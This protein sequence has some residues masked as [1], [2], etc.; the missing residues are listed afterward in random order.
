[1]I[2]NNTTKKYEFTGETKEYGGV[3]L[4]RIRRLSDKLLGGWIEKES[5]LSQD[6][7]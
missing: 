5:N 3:S 4:K 7:T 1:M 2:N 6:G